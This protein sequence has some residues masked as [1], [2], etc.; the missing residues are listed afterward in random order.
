MRLPRC[1]SLQQPM[2][3]NIPAKR[4]DARCAL[5]GQDSAG[6]RDEQCGEE[7]P[8]RLDCGAE[9]ATGCHRSGVERSVSGLPQRRG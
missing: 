6:V 3:H 4:V 8:G 9:A 7:G 1:Q 2:G 5:E